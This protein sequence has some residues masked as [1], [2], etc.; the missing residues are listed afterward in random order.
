MPPASPVLEDA[1][2][3]AHMLSPDQD[4]SSLRDKKRYLESRISFSMYVDIF[5]KGLSRDAGFFVSERLS[6]C[7]CFL[8]YM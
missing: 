5:G 7:S 8:S 4:S 6:G 2:A 3:E 1:A